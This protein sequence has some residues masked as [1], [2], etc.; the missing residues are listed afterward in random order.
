M[1]I[2]TPQK[3]SVE[4][5]NKNFLDKLIAQQM[6]DRSRQV[7]QLGSPLGTLEFISSWLQVLKERCQEL[8]QEGER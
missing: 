1:K 2:N 3:L 7:L 8:I 5:V 6:A 4:K